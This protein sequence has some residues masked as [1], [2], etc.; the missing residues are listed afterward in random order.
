[1]EGLHK[2]PGCAR[3]PSMLSQRS[4]SRL[5]I[6]DKV[7][8]SPG[9]LVPRGADAGRLGRQSRAGFDVPTTYI[10]PSSSPVSGRSCM[11]FAP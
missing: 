11:T 10:P 6:P 4:V 9:R 2:A 5:R 7:A 8:G 3:A 1:M